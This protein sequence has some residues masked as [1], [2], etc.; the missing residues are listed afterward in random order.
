[1][2]KE[3]NTLGENYHSLTLFSIN[4]VMREETDIRVQ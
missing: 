2:E 1:M 4:L 3:I